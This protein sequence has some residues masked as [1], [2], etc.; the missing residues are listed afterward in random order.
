VNDSGRLHVYACVMMLLLQIASPLDA[1]TQHTVRRAETLSGIA[2]RYAVSVSQLRAWNQLTNDTIQIG[3]KLAVAVDKYTVRA[4]DNL[5]QIA[6]RFGIALNDLRRYNSL[7]SDQIAIGQ[8]LRLKPAPT[9]TRNRPPADTYKV[10]RGDTLSEI[11]VAHRVSLASLRQLNNVRGDRLQ[12]GQTLRL[13]QPAPVTEEEVPPLYTVQRGD[14]LSSIGARFDVGLRMLRQLNGLTGD[15]ITPGQK[16]RLRPSLT[17]EGIHVVHAG[18]TL[19]EIAVLH[20]VELAQLRRI[21]GLDGDLIRIGQKLRLR[22]TP[23]TVH[24]VERGDAL[25]EIARA[26]GMSVSRVRELNDLAGDRIYPGQE[27]V[28]EASAERRFATYTVRRGD[29]L[30]EIAQLHQMGVDEVRRLNELDGTVIHPG[31]KLRVRPLNAHRRWVEQSDIPWDQLL[32]S[33][34]SLKRIELVN[35]PY[36]ATRPKADTQ[37]GKSYAELHPPTPLATFHQARNLFKK[38]E[39]A[40]EGVG[41]LSDALAGW[42]IVLDPGHGG[43]DPGAIVPTVDGNGDRLYVVEDEYVYDVALRTYVLFRLHGANVDIT[44][45]SPN[46]LFRHSGIPPTKTFVHEQNEVFNSLVHNRPNRPSVWPTGNPSGLRARVQIAREA[47]QGVPKERTIFLSF[48]ADIDHNSPAAPLVLYYESRDGKQRDNASRRF[49]RS[50]LP[51]LGAGAHTR[52]QS[53]GVLRNNP[54]GV[55]ALVEVGNLAHIDHAWALRYERL[56]H[57]NA[58]KVVRGVLDYAGGR[59]VALR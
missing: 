39:E 36:F 7:R 49:A 22:S 9:V 30:S 14:N 16:L 48:H 25:W 53:L 50:L 6:L 42:H 59:R 24:V 8:S 33:P 43:V 55:K 26:Y 57:R 1:A 41:R 4:G 51:A 37:R 15:H 31:Q 12:V 56:R 47:F 27:L 46:H 40:I 3:Q 44:L 21:N 58:E 28:L 2:K 54:A 20:S 5:S 10:R 11:A 52:G 18:Q 19:S 29:N 45:L 34:A 13:R 35:G 32:V 38:F 23:T 17:E